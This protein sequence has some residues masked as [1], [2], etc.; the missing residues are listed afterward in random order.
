MGDLV[1][2]I[3]CMGLIGILVQWII[4][5]HDDNVM[6]SLPAILCFWYKGNLQDEKPMSGQIPQLTVSYVGDIAQKL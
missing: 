3:G 1:L 2:N 6:Q 5:T 4:N